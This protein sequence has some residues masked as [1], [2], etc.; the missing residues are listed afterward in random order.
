MAK[1]S[2]RGRTVEAKL[3]KTQ[4][5]VNS[6]GRDY[7]VKIT[8][9][10]CSDRVVLQKKQTCTTNLKAGEE[11]HTWSTGYTVLGNVP[12]AMSIVD[13]IADHLNKGWQ[14]V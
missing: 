14:T 5:G 3:C 1:L 9:A 2:A 10:I 4:E 8:R 11:H 7:T 12:E 6:F 13:C